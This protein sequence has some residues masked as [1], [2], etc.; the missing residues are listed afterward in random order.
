MMYYYQKAEIPSNITG[1]KH[2][3]PRFWAGQITHILCANAPHGKYVPTRMLLLL[4]LITFSFGPVSWS[5]AQTGGLPPQELIIYPYGA[6][7]VKT[8]LA[9]ESRTRTPVLQAFPRRVPDPE[10][11]QQYKQQ[12]QSESSP[13]PGAALPSVSGLTP[14]VLQSFIGLRKAESCNCVP[15]VRKWRLGLGTSLKW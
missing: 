8:L 4:S 14:D 15:P 5:Q 6:V 12:M 9:P 1:Y 11:R 2:V 10:A 3:S 13:G 7:G